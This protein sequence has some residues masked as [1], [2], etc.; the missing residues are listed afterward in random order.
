[1]Q[2]PDTTED[3]L[4]SLADTGRAV[5][6]FEHLDQTYRLKLR[7]FV[8]LAMTPVF[9][10]LHRQVDYFALRR[11]GITA[12]MYFLDFQAA[13]DKLVFGRPV[14]VHHDTRLYRARTPDFRRPAGPPVERLLLVSEVEMRGRAWQGATE[15][16][17]F[18]AGES[19]EVS[20]GRARLLQVV[21]RPLA[22]AGG[23][24]I[25]EPPGQL[26]RLRVH[27]WD[28]PYPTEAHLGELPEG[29]AAVDTGLAT[30]HGVWGLP[31]TDINQH[32]NTLEFIMGLENHLSRQL[33]AAG[34][35]LARHR[36]LR[37]RMVFRK[38]SFAGEPYV[39]R[40]GLFRRG[41]ATRLQ[42]GF[43]RVR[44]GAEDAAP[45]VFGLLEGLL[46]DEGEAP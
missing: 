25:T 2:T 38:P 24:R 21:T 32:V 42:A 44:D 17:G 10:N 7:G 20:A 39:L 19:P 41:A 4:D 37:G 16:L 15:T 28:E 12:V 9:V 6:S 5:A 22:P 43:H 46:P 36:T 1:M 13:P 30:E 3:M 23:R 27:P 14:A 29:F 11:E 35:P 33:H 18:D 31:N 45:A 26:A 8:D 40:G 34:L